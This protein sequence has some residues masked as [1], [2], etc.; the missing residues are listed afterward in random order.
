MSELLSIVE[1]IEPAKSSEALQSMG[2]AFCFHRHH[3][4]WQPNHSDKICPESDRNKSL[5]CAHSNAPILK[6]GIESLFYLQRITQEQGIALLSLLCTNR[7]GALWDS[8]NFANVCGVVISTDGGI[9]RTPEAIQERQLI[10]G[11]S[12]EVCPV[13]NLTPNN[14]IALIAQKHKEAGKLR[15]ELRQLLIECLSPDAEIECTQGKVT[16]FIIRHIG[17]TEESH[18]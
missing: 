3:H 12:R 5:Y 2:T 11:I 9:V 1:E 10:L 14:A 7:S 6:N 16:D 18:D 17:E 8:D 13:E 15:R 4:A